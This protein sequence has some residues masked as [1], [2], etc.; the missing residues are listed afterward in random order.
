M[1]NVIL[2][3]VIVIIVVDPIAAGTRPEFSQ[4]VPRIVH[5]ETPESLV[6]AADVCFSS[7]RQIDDF[8]N[9]SDRGRRREAAVRG[10]EETPSPGLPLRRL[11]TRVRIVRRVAD[12]DATEA[13]HGSKTRWGGEKRGGKKNQ[14]KKNKIEG[15]TERRINEKK[16]RENV[17][18]RGFGRAHG[19]GKRKET[20]ARDSISA[21]RG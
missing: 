15:R 8:P 11:Y 18:K 2:V 3:V 1:F 4:P 20:S 10:T 13:A 16:Q 6:R 17:R 12:R 5:G 7:T 21:R 19:R 14:E 9:G